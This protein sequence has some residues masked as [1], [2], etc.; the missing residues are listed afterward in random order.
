[1][2]IGDLVKVIEND[3]SKIFPIE[4]LKNNRFFDQ[5]GV[6]IEEPDYWFPIRRHNRWVVQFPAGIYHACEGAIE[7]ITKKNKL[8]AT[9]SAR[10]HEKNCLE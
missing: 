2:K 4:G 1:M 8:P 5:I 10:E 7:V 9:P 3:M 6:I